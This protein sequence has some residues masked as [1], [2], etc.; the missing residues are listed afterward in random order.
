MNVAY[1]FVFSG[2]PRHQ[3]ICRS[4]DLPHSFKWLF[5]FLLLHTTVIAVPLFGYLWWKE[6]NFYLNYKQSLLD[7]TQRMSPKH[8]WIIKKFNQGYIWI[9]KLYMFHSSEWIISSHGRNTTF[10]RVYCVIFSLRNLYS[11]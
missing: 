10:I 6:K 9:Y 3:E 1:G 8:L 11:K 4:R 5:P 2:K 7:K